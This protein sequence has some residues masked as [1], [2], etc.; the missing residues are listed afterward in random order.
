MTTD[1]PKVGVAPDAPA[2]P[3]RYDWQEIVD[4][5]SAISASRRPPSA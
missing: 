2:P 3:D 1:T 5:C 4:G